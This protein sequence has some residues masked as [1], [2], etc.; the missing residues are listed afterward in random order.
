MITFNI[1]ELL[2]TILLLGSAQAFGIKQD[3][4]YKFVKS[5][6]T[7]ETMDR[8]KKLNKIKVGLFGGS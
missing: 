2:F 4:L 3:S 6:T 7:I 1:R 5:K 8:I